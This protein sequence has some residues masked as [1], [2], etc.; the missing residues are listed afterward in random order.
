MAGTE[1]LHSCRST[2]IFPVGLG[3]REYSVEGLIRFL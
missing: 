2:V 3:E 1:D